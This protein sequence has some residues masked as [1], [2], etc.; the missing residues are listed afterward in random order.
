MK[1]PFVRKKTIKQICEQIIMLWLVQLR[2]YE[3][4]FRVSP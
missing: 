2:I 1:P 3:Y 4:I